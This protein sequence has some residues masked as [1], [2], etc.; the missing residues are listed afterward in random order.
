M[1]LLFAADLHMDPL[2]WKN[3][4]DVRDDAHDSWEQI[5]KIAIERKVGGVILGGDVFDQHPPPITL[6]C[7]LEGVERLKGANIRVGAIQGQHG[8]NRKLA[9]SSVDP[10]DYVIDL[11]MKT[12]DA[13][14]LVVG[15]IDNLPPNQLK[16]ALTE[17][18]PSVNVLVLHQMMKGIVP[19]FGG[20]E[21]WDCEPEW[22]PRHVKL[23]LLGDY[24][25]PMGRTFNHVLFKYNGSTVLRSIDE[26]PEKYCHIVNEDFS[27]EMVMLKTRVIKK[28]LL[29]QESLSEDDTKKLCEEVMALPDESVVYFKHNPRLGTEFLRSVNP[30]VYCIFKPIIIRD[31]KQPEKCEDVPR[32]T[33]RGC[34]DRS[35][36]REEQP[37]LYD[38]LVELL[39]TEAPAEV[40]A[41]HKQRCMEEI[42]ADVPTTEGRAVLPAQESGH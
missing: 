21:I 37:A 11:N 32:V 20:R 10:D 30:R 25:S 13:G 29:T 24:H 1:K 23:V 26:P 19:N 28:F 22:I 34:L 4:P 27:P 31:D 42:D 14:P 7:F 17:V 41:I 2:I 15:G 5:V 6:R 9:W 12:L 33:L 3:M 38:F 8:R 18:H 16:E 40:I 36:D 39:L 35:L